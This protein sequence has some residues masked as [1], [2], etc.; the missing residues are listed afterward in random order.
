M[1]VLVPPHVKTVVLVIKRLCLCFYLLQLINYIL[2]MVTRHRKDIFLMDSHLCNSIIQVSASLRRQC[3]S[4]VRPC[5]Q[6]FKKRIIGEAFYHLSFRLINF[7]FFLQ[8]A[9]QWKVKNANLMLTCCV[10]NRLKYCCW[11]TCCGE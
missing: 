9:I 7:N 6:Y 5:Y 2:K 3:L 11:H 1:L 8:L 10:S 4:W